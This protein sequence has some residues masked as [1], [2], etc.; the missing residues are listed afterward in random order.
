MAD[1]T[2]LLIESDEEN[3][4]FLVQLL[5]TRNYSVFTASTGKEGLM[6]AFDYLPALMICD[7]NLPDL[8]PVEL[9]EKF[10]QQ[11]QLA[12]IAAVA[13]SP[14]AN[15]KEMEVC[16]QVGYSE[17]FIKS[18]SAAM[19]M[20]DSIPNIIAQHAQK[21]VGEKNGVLC[22]FLSAKGGTGTSSLCANIGMNLAGYMVKSS[23]ALADMVL[24][25]GSVADIV[26]YKGDFSIAYVSQREPEEI[27]SEYLKEKL[28]TP[29]G[30]GFQ[31]L[32][33]SSDPEVASRI[34]VQRFGDIVTAMRQAYGYVLIDFGRTLSRFSL[35]ILQQSDAIVLI[36]STDMNT[37]RVTKKVW[38]YLQAQG[39]DRSQMFPI[40]NRAVGME[41]LSKAEVEAILGLEIRL[42]VPYMGGNFSLANNQNM[43]MTTK[44]PSDTVSM[45][46][47]QAAVDLSRMALKKHST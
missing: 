10:R 32:P 38:E 22:T 9:L 14:Q 45:V 35:P 4:K 21:S 11:P 16:L 8:G 37:A 46:L 5:R 42:T 29:T 39:V 40:L 6:R 43:P 34:N 30:W 24:P 20:V 18:G 15:P 31:L 1:N 47:H 13:L 28:I 27:N 23:V 17:Y 33:G 2:I 19:T 44:F 3:R 12:H 26:G 36:L 25:I 41:G 7:T